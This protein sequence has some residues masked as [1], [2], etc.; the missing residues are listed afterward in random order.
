[1][2]ATNVGQGPM[3]HASTAQEKQCQKHKYSKSTFYSGNY[4][5]HKWYHHSGCCI[6]ETIPNTSIGVVE[7]KTDS[8]KNQYYSIHMLELS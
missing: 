5:E 2:P 8:H 4:F 3:L 6:R 1:M 7:K